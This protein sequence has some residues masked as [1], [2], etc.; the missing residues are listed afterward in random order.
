MFGLTRKGIAEKLVAILLPNHT[1]LDKKKAEEDKA[2]A[3]SN[4]ETFQ[5]MKN[6]HWNLISDNSFMAGQLISLKGELEGYRKPF[7][8]D[9]IIPEGSISFPK[10]VNN[11]KVLSTKAK[12]SL[13]FQISNVLNEKELEAGLSYFNFAL[14]RIKKNQKKNTNE[15]ATQGV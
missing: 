15:E 8:E 6:M 13:V 14:D 12:T 10:S 11:F 5:R 3:K 1:L 9:N 4:A 7:I 2:K